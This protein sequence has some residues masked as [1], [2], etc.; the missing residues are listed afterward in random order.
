M[1]EKNFKWLILACVVVIGIAAAIDIFG[2]AAFQ[3]QSEDQVKQ[4]ACQGIC[5]AAELAG[6]VCA[7]SHDG[8]EYIGAVADFHE[9]TEKCVDNYFTILEHID[10][11]CLQETTVLVQS[12]QTPEQRDVCELFDKCFK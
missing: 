2:C 7:E 6:P 4:M 8:W 11:T 3:D 1:D 10:V 5:A 12:K 9:C